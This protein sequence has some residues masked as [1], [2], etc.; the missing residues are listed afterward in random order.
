MERSRAW[1]PSVLFLVGAAME[2]A[3]AT[4][5]KQP[6][7]YGVGAAF[8]GVGVVFLSRARKKKQPRLRP[9]KI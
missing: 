6:A 7:F 9:G 5:G 8:I 1:L 3:S 4:I 2:F